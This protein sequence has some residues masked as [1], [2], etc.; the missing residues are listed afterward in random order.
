MPKLYKDELISWVLKAAPFADRS[1]FVI[2]SGLRLAPEALNDIALRWISARPAVFQTHY[3]MVA[4]L[5]CGLSA[6]PIAHFVQRWCKKFSKKH[7]LSFVARA[8]L[9]AGGDKTVVE[10]SVKEWLDAHKTDANAQFIYHAWLNA[11]GDKVLVEEPIK[12][13]LGVHKTEVEAEF[14]YRAWLNAGGDTALVEKP[15]KEWLV[16]HKIKIEASFVYRAWLNAGGDTSLVEKPIKE[17]L[18]VHKTNA[19]ASFVYEAWLNAGGDTALVEKPIKEWLVVYKTNAEASFVYHAWLNAGG[20]H[21]AVWDSSEWDSLLLWLAEHQTDK[22]AGYITKLVAKH[23]DLPAALVKNILAWCR[24]F[25]VNEDVLWRV[26]QLGKNL[27]NEDVLDDACA[28]TETLLSHIIGSSDE[29]SE[30]TRGQVTTLLNYLVEGARL[31]SR[32]MCNRVDTLIVTWMKCPASFGRKPKPYMN[33]QRLEFARRVLLLLLSGEL[34]FKQDRNSI[35]RFLQWLDEWDI[36]R[37]DQLHPTIEA[38]S[39]RY[40]APEVWNIVRFE[41]QNEISEVE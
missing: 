39:K 4:W 24:A 18:V 35:E 15:I 8:W 30:V 22:S 40:P 19:E 12:D 29:V 6:D 14:V 41:G 1:N 32:T 27:L 20:L 38:Y 5:E 34:D 2:T 9:E 10:Q 31:H 26:T 21:S 13:W 28:T 36:L 17:W 11:K 33:I 7:H 37:K 16:V 23:P 25:P 3:L